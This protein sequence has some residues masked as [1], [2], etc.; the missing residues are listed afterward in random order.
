MRRRTYHGQV[1]PEENEYLNGSIL[2]SCDSR[3][4]WY[5]VS[6]TGDVTFS[7]VMSPEEG[8]KEYYANVKAK[9]DSTITI[10]IDRTRLP[11]YSNVEFDSNGESYGCVFSGN[12]YEVTIY[13]KDNEWYFSINVNIYI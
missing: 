1:P 13:P 6:Y 10:V 7:D 3:S 9:K 2:I 11:S 5:E 4:V 8:D 12:K